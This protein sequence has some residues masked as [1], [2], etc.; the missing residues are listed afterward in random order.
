MRRQ[1]EKIVED[2]GEYAYRLWTQ[3]SYISY[4]AMD[5]LPKTFDHID[6][7]LEAHPL[8]NNE[9]EDDEACL[10]GKDILIVS[11]PAII[12]YGNLDGSDYSTETILRKAVVW[13][14]P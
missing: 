9:I 2:L 11:Q 13:M 5:K 4:L 10:D 1:L 7:L 14:G 6:G 12:A 8:H 3:K